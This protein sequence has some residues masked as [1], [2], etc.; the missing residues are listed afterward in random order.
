MLVLCKKHYNIEGVAGI[1]WV[2]IQASMNGNGEESAPRRAG[3]L[4]PVLI[5]QDEAD[6]GALGFGTQ[7]SLVTLTCQLLREQAFPGWV[8]VRGEE[9]PDRA[10]TGLLR[11]LAVKEAKKREPCEWGKVRSRTFS[12]VQENGH[13]VYVLREAIWETSGRLMMQERG[14][15][16]GGGI[17]D[18]TAP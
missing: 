6:S 11:N 8:R 15:S 14:E 10:D 5:Q 13:R 17:L 18:P 16:F 7:R 1:R 3:H 2:E 12:F 9:E 4:C